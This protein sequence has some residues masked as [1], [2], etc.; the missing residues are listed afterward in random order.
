M[1][2][3]HASYNLTSRTSR[4]P[5]WLGDAD[6]PARWSE[7]SLH[8]AVKPCEHWFGP[9]LEFEVAAP[10]SSGPPDPL[11]FLSNLISEMK[12]RRP[13]EDGGSTNVG[14]VEVNGL[15]PSASTLRT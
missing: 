13:S 9:A 11:H 10:S 14:L 3:G 2:T 12:N 1:L 7:G 6:S 5:G 15:E 4:E 8:V